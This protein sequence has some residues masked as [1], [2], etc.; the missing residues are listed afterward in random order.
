[1]QL[2]GSC[3]RK[4]NIWIRYSK[5]GNTVKHIWIPVQLNLPAES[6]PGVKEETEPIKMEEHFMYYKIHIVFDWVHNWPLYKLLVC[7]KYSGTLFEVSTTLSRLHITLLILNIGV[8]SVT[9][10][11]IF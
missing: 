10:P 2:S 8:V 1:M 11:I 3:Q 5:Y 9:G 6:V 4:K 7:Q